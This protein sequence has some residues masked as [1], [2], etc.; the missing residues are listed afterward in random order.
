[1]RR[2]E[3]RLALS[4]FLLAALGQA[5]AADEPGVPVAA[6]AHRPH[7][8]SMQFQVN[9]NFRLSGFEGAGLAVTRNAG[10]A[11]A[12]RLGLTWSGDFS[13]TDGSNQVFVNDTLRVDQKLP[14]DDEDRVSVRVDLLRL[15]RFHPGRR[16]G[17]EFGLGPRFQFD[18]FR[19][20]NEFPNGS[21]DER[22]D[23]NLF[24][25]VE[26]RMGGELFVARAVSLHAHYGARLGYQDRK[27][28]AESESGPEFRRSTRRAKG[29][30]LG[31]EGVTFGVSVYL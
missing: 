27:M 22:V 30:N 16:A 31:T 6:D 21:L 24:Y 15:H 1:M 23:R 13:N 29:V 4:V 18:R 9:D 17:V 10:A 19:S 8:W 26:A 28:V 25:G 5:C 20:R 14:D 2:T 7:R 11:D 12:W 3:T